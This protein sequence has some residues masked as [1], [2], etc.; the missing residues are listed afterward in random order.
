MTPLSASEQVYRFVKETILNGQIAA[1]D[2]ITEGQIVAEMSL[3]RTPV[4]EAFLRLASEGWLKLYPKRGA[5]VVPVQPQ[6]MEQVLEARHLIE[7]HAVRTIARNPAEANALGQCLLTITAQMQRAMDEQDIE[8]FT[9]LDTEFH[10]TIVRSADNDILSDIYQGLRDRLRRMTIRS[11]WRDESRMQGI[12]KDH[13]DLAHI[14]E[15]ADVEA[16]STRL[17]EHMLSTHSRASGRPAR[18]AVPSHSGDSTRP[19]SADQ[20]RA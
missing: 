7:T 12:I 20:H 11:V 18:F 13:T 15:R 19:D 9:S 8:S 10:L 16:Y 6:E 17:L 14:V 5:L 3:S 1:G 4:R 2:M